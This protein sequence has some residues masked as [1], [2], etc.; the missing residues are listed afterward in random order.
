MGG[1]CGLVKQARISAGG[2]GGARETVGG[3]R[4][5]VAGP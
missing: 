2:V 1:A 4:E 3:A 5:T